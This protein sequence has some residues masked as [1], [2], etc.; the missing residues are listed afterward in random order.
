M[1]IINKNTV[2]SSTRYELFPPDNIATV[3]SLFTG[4][5]FSE[6]ELITAISEAAAAYDEGVTTRV[7]TDTDL[8]DNVVSLYDAR[9]TKQLRT[10][11]VSLLLPKPCLTSE[12]VTPKFQLL[13]ICTPLLHDPI[14]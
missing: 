7:F 1:Y 5:K 2:M 10:L 13:R 11:T 4:A 9:Q 6:D 8:L 14:I 3:Y 12:T